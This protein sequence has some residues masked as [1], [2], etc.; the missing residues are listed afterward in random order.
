[1]GSEELIDSMGEHDRA[2]IAEGGIKQTNL[3]KVF[4][5]GF[6]KIQDTVSQLYHGLDGDSP[7]PI[8]SFWR[9]LFLPSPGLTKTS[10]M[11][12]KLPPIVSIAQQGLADCVGAVAG[13]VIT[14]ITDT[15]TTPKFY[16]DFLTLALKHGLAVRD[17][18]GIQV[19]PSVL[20]ILTTPDYTSLFPSPVVTISYKRG[21]SLIDIFQVVQDLSK[22]KNGY[23]LYVLCPVS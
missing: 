11:S 2:Y 17:D 4:D 12:V 6:P 1:M 20:N 16:Q 10:P 5:K 9:W 13:S 15:P 14:T 18:S 21:L 3:L 7:V 8:A 22:K 23:N 19:D